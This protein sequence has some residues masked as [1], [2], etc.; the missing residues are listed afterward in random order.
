MKITTR[1]ANECVR[2]VL[3]NIGVKEDDLTGLEEAAI[4]RVTAQK[5]LE[6]C[7]H[8]IYNAE[9]DIWSMVSQIEHDLKE[10]K[11]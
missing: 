5:L 2:D 10:E 11:S 7:D 3:I 4:L 9:I 6:L 8:Y 1:I